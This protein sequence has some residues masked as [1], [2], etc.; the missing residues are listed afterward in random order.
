MGGTVGKTPDD[1]GKGERRDGNLSSWFTSAHLAE[2]DDEL[3]FA[4]FPHI[5]NRKAMR[6]PFWKGSRSNST[7]IA[8]RSC[9]IPDFYRSPSPLITRSNGA[10]AH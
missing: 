7:G 3:R 2:N 8:P 4:F 10:E 1:G 9:T 5:D 6:K